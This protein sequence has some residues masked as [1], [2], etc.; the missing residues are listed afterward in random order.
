MAKCY[1]ESSGISAADW[2][3]NA[4]LR[5]ADV[6]I[7]V[8]AACK[9]AVGGEVHQNSERRRSAR[10]VG[11]HAH[12]T[13]KA[14]ETLCILVENDGRLVEK[15]RLLETLWADSFVE[16]GNIADN[17]SKIRQAL[18][19]NP[20]EPKFIETV[21]G[22][23]YRFV[24]QVR[25]VEEEEKERKGEE[26]IRN[27]TV[28]SEL[29]AP[30]DELSE[31]PAAAGGLKAAESN[32]SSDEL[33]NDDKSGSKTFSFGDFELDGAKRLLLKKSRAV[34]L[35][36][37]AFDLLL[38]LVENCGAVLTKNELLDKV[39]ANQFVEENNLTVHISALRKTTICRCLRQS[40]PRR[41]FIQPQM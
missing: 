36:P 7:S 32:L 28:A 18:G 11:Y 37:K 15:N 10:R 34:A 19:D 6:I 17:V 20:K 8:A 30:T 3:P 21:S 25:R 40:R 14:F 5:A 27:D 16:E 41:G 38:T 24:A 35:N 22:R 26:E 29:L 9:A 39:W 1:G 33:Q 4:I 2:F 23:G 13:P 12:P 31:P